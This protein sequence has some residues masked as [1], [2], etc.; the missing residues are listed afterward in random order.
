MKTE[1][2]KEQKQPAPQKKLETVSQQSV[3]ET[4]KKPEPP[5]S[6]PKNTD[7]GGK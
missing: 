4:A 5:K 2:S 7:S 1:V 6:T 3:P